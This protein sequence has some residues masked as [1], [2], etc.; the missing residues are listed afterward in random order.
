MGRDKIG[1]YTI[2]LIVNLKQTIIS[3]L[4]KNSRVTHFE[5]ATVPI[6]QSEP[7]EYGIVPTGPQGY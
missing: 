5:R 3:I 6:L 1:I 4:S 7:R 2:K